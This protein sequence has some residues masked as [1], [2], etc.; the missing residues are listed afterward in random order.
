M[1]IYQRTVSDSTT[2]NAITTTHMM[3]HLG[4]FTLR[5]GNQYLH[6]KTDITTDMMMFFY[7]WGYLYNSASLIGWGASY[8]YSGTLINTN[9]YNVGSTTFH[10]IYR[11]SASP[12]NVCLRFNRNGTGYSEGRINVFFAT[13]GLGSRPTVV[14]FSENNNSGNY[15]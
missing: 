13:H 10:G 11:T 15:Y 8:T 3:V 9:L 14:A 6:L 12:Y 4:E 7:A 1:S 5:D 2:I